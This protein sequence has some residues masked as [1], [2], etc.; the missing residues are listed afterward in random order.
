MLTI[1]DIPEPMLEQIRETFDRDP[2]VCWL[3]TQQAL[4][5][6]RGKFI[7]A[8]KLA[9]DIDI[10][11]AKVVQT[12]IDDAERETSSIHLDETGMPEE[13][14]ESLLEC[15]VT[16]FMCCDVMDTAI[17]DANDIVKRTDKDLCFDMFND[18]SKLARMAK[19]KLK[20]LQEN[21]GYAKDVVWA[22]RCD[23]MYEMMRNKARSIIRKRKS[24]PNWGKSC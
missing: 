17:M 5:Q 7:E 12:F 10:I 8:M 16:L 20:F 1:K 15:V 4:L 3:R 19:D 24:D 14:I 2:K 11:Y 6:K 22:D 9:K 18:I 23:N 13:D 21:S